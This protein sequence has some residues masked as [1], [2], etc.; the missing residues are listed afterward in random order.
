MSTRLEQIDLKGNRRQA[1]PAIPVTYGRDSSTLIPAGRR[2]PAKLSTHRTSRPPGSMTLRQLPV[3]QPLPLCK[4]QKA[5]VRI[6]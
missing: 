4:M 1:S 5:V 2:R 6:E 3:L